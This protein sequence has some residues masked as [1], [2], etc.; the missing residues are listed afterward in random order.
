M[1]CSRRCVS[2][3]AVALLVVTGGAAVGCS[4]SQPPPTDEVDDL[5]EAL[6][7]EARAEMVGGNALDL[8]NN[9]EIFDAMEHDIRD[10]RVSV[11]IVI[12]IWR[13]EDGPSR[14]IGEA[15][16]NRRAGVACRLVVDA[17][18]SLKFSD[19]LEQRL[20]ASGCDVRRYGLRGDVRLMARN[21]RKIQVTDGKTGVTGGWGVW[22]VWEGDGLSRDAWR[23]TAVRVSG[24]AVAQMQ[25]AF[26]QSWVEAGGAPLPAVEYP[27]LSRPGP[28]RATFV[29]SSP[30]RDQKS[31]AEIMTELVIGSAHRQL[32]IAS[33]YFVPN[34][35]LGDLLIRK[36]RQGVDVRVLAA[37][38]VHDVP[39]VRAAQRATYERLLEAGVRIF[40][41]KP[42]MMHSKTM[43]VDGRTVVIGSTNFDQLSFD[44]LEEGS[45]VAFAP[46][47]ARKLLREFDADFGRSLEITREL[48]ADR[49]LLPDL[50]RRASALFA[51][52]L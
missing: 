39:P 27:K 13:G 32:W 18:G 49:D 43:V 5:A 25:R 30:R 28:T 21:H 52:W 6:R 36:R 40:E 1:P 41:Y 51:D 31:E 24:P 35:T 50:A 33:S 16:L 7:R 10:A 48:W 19:T 38:P 29:A 12:Y 44:R 17:F 11:N 4:S 2:Q 47:L 20:T 22:R 8:I 46:I 15:L 3:M 42:S 9:G 34:E 45:M 26:E 23:D 14:R 37:G